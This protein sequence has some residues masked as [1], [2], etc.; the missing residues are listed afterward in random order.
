MELHITNG[1]SAAGFIRTA[2]CLSSEQLLTVNDLLCCGPLSVQRLDSQWIEMRQQFWD[3]LLTQCAIEPF[4][5][6][7]FTR[8]FYFNHNELFAAKTVHLWTGTSL[9]DQ[10]MLA[11]VITHFVR[12]KI[13]LDKLL[14]HQFEYHPE[15]NFEISGITLLESEHIVDGG[16]QFSLSSLEI[17][18]LLDGWKAVADN[19]PQKLVDF[20]GKEDVLPLFHKALKHLI[21]RFPEKQSG[22][23]IWEERIL[24]SV[25]AGESNAARIIGHLLFDYSRQ[26]DL[27]GD[28]YLFYLIKSLANSCFQNP[29]LTSNQAQGTMHDTEVFL[30]ELGEKILDKKENFVTTNGIDR[31]IAGIHLCSQSNRVWYRKG[32]SLEIQA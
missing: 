20:I 9:G 13:G 4:P 30:T 19:T 6:S 1:S 27:V 29:L 32:E 3:C 14:V 21:Y 10:L 24:A 22:L 5:M 25:K 18:C 7:E 17:K 28:I 11:F 26:P 2:L 16:N 31:Y 15:K 12:E 8:D 23:S